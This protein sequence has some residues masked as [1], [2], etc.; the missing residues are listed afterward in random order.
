MEKQGERFFIIRQKF[1]YV[2]DKLFNK[3]VKK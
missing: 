2:M 1:I 3:N